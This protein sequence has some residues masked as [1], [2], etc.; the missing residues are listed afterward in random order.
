MLAMVLYAGFFPSRTLPAL[1]DSADVEAGR[2]TYYPGYAMASA[3][4]WIW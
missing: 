2:I 3:T 1:H 4:P